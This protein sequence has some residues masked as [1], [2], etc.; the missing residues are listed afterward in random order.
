MY[1]ITNKVNTY[2]LLSYSHEA[3]ADSS[4]FNEGLPIEN[5]DINLKYTIRSA[6]SL[7]KLK[8]QHLIS[9]TGP[10]LVSHKL[11]KILQTIAPNELEFYETTILFKDT[12]IEGFSAINILN[13]LPCCNMEE[14]EY[15]V[16]NFDQNN[17]IY[18]FLY[19]KLKNIAPNNVNIFRCSEQPTLII[20]NEKIKKACQREGIEGIAFYKSIDLTY[21]DRTSE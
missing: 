17:P 21:G 12:K 15:E 19:T 2:N 18:M 1:I 11:K 8:K 20:V 5:S 6:A 3:S 13:L 7:N 16:T 10:E 14:S 4:L 9:T